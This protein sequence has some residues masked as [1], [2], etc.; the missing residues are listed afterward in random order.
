[1]ICVFLFFYF[2][3]QADV[4]SEVFFQ[5]RGFSYEERGEANEEEVSALTEVYSTIINALNDKFEDL[6][7]LTRH[8][9][10]LSFVRNVVFSYLSFCDSLI[11]CLWQAEIVLR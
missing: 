11:V 7:T 3:K 10:L 1:M 9:L 5:E 4:A 8:E 2:L 6:N